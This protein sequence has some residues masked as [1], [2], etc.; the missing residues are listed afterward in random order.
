ML[1]CIQTLGWFKRIYNTTAQLF[2]QEHSKMWLWRMGINKRTEATENVWLL[3][4]HQT[5]GV[6]ERLLALIYWPHYPFLC[7]ALS[8]TQCWWLYFAGGATT[9]QQFGGG[10]FIYLF[11]C[12]PKMCH[13][14]EH[15]PSCPR[16]CHDTISILSQFQSKTQY[17]CLSHLMYFFFSWQKKKRFMINLK[18]KSA[19]KKAKW[20][21]ATKTKP[22]TV[23]F[24][25][26]SLKLSATLGETLWKIR[27]MQ[28]KINPALKFICFRNKCVHER[29]LFDKAGCVLF[30]YLHFW[31]SALLL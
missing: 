5:V 22:S 2:S 17:G 4:C 21:Q 18:A 20:G 29:A 9:Q 25:W 13:K 6:V 7:N 15:L 12:L 27:N 10:G 31:P 19:C 30:N 8:V 3:S 1:H 28:W 23:A 26:V 24:V 11:L 14:F 16:T